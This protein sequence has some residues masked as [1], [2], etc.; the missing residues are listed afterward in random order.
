MLSDFLVYS[1]KYVITLWPQ[2]QATEEWLTLLSVLEDKS[3]V[4]RRV[5]IVKKFVFFFFLSYL[6]EI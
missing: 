1:L 3:L 5:L 2:I 4:D 6:D